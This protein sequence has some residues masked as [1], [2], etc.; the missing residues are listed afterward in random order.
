MSLSDI[1]RKLG[2]MSPSSD[3]SDEADE[4]GEPVDT[5]SEQEDSEE[6][7]ELRDAVRT[8][9]SQLKE[10]EAELESTTNSTKGLRNDLTGVE[11]DMEKM[12]ERIRKLLGFY[13]ALAARINPLVKGDF[14]AVPLL[15]ALDKESAESP[16]DLDE[17][18]EYIEMQPEEDDAE[19]EPEESHVA[20][21]EEG[22]ED[23]ADDPEVSEHT[24][25]SDEPART[26]ADLKRDA[27]EQ[28]TDPTGDAN[29]TPHV[30]DLPGTYGGELIALEW[31]ATLVD[32]A[33]TA[34]AL[35][36]LL[37][38]QSIGWISEEV[39]R[40]LQRRLMGASESSVPQETDE[41]LKAE[42]HTMSLAY[43][44]QLEEMFEN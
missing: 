29:D 43:V 18:P 15:D 8:L 32:R 7:E 33:G 14:R 4:T 25:V 21:K 11:E 6:V 20:S 5:Q 3:E 40:A 36:A 35:R 41:L 22:D 38:Y 16:F 9:Q 24:V 42:D 10:V 44:V 30:S 28:S 37:Y 19:T 13:D 27:E 12:K 17:E 31:L 26:I 2:I 39:K 23:K 34:G 1:L